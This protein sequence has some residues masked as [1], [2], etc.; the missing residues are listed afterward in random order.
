[1]VYDWARAECDRWQTNLEFAN[2]SDYFTSKTA[3]GTSYQVLTVQNQTTQTSDRIWMN[4]VWLYN[5]KLDRY[6]WVYSYEYIASEAD[7]KQSDVGTWGPIVETF[8]DSFANTNEL[9]FLDTY[10]QSSDSIDNWNDWS[11]LSP[12]QTTLRDDGLG[13]RQIFLDANYSFAVH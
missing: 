3:H 12:E 1:M 2:L 8:Q 4:N 13:F 5:Y 11:L 10:V 9:G 7:Q 6:D